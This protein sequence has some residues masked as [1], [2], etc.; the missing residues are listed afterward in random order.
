MLKLFIKI[1]FKAKTAQKS[2]FFTSPKLAILGNL[3]VKVGNLFAKIG[4][5]VATYSHCQRVKI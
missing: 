5:N 2:L 4:K 3:N 1:P